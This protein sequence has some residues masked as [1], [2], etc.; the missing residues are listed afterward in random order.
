MFPRYPQS[1]AILPT[2][3]CPWKK[4]GRKQRGSGNNCF[5]SCREMRLLRW[6]RLPS[7]LRR[8]CKFRLWMSMRC[9]ST[10]YFSI[11]FFLLPRVSWTHE[12]RSLQVGLAIEG[13]PHRKRDG[14]RLCSAL[15]I[16]FS[17][18][19]RTQQNVSRCHT[20][21]KCAFVAKVCLCAVPEKVQVSGPNS[22]KA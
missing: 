5:R 22:S 9:P 17:G 3:Y 19:T 15:L 1:S 10:G 12:S 8:P 2:S 6:R 16:L 13:C 20:S 18:E 14:H 7:G 11:R 4:T 21:C